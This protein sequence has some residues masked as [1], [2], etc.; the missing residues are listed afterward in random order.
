MV[1]IMTNAQAASSQNDS[2]MGELQDQSSG[3]RTTAEDRGDAGNAL[4]N[5]ERLDEPC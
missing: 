2:P 3:E 1:T 4:H 5:V